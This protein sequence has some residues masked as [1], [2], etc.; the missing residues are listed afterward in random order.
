MSPPNT[1]SISDM[2]TTLAMQIAKP[3]ERFTSGG[4]V[5]NFLRDIGIYFDVLNINADQQKAL[6]PA[7]IEP[8]L[9][10]RYKIAEKEEKTWQ[11]ALKMA[12]GRITTMQEDIMA[13]FNF[14]KDQKSVA[15]YVTAVDKF[16][17]NIMRHQTSK[18]KIWRMVVNASIND[19]EMKKAFIT[20]KPADS[21]NGDRADSN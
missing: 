16:V 17:D 8:E 7:F 20:N 14:K 4:D 3:P 12:F 21:K 13:A 10:E 6:I 2:A 9:V 15:Q 11:A 1:R 19:A 5:H 18:K